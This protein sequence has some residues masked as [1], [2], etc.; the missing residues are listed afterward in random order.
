MLQEFKKFILRGNVVELAIAVII[1]TAFGR[2]TTSLVND[3]LMPI[4]GI[5]VGG[6]NFT[7]LKIVIKEAYGETAELALYYGNFIQ[8]II[9]FLIIGFALFLI[10]KLINSMHRKKKE[11]D[12]PPTP[13]KEE[14]LLE[15]IRDI[16]KERSS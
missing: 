2:I 9:D 1:G 15:E 14:I 8:S 12:A 13:S 16:L 6:I 7:D 3:V 11:P 5:F 4:L 10:I